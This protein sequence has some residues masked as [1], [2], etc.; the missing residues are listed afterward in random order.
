MTIMV[1]EAGF[2]PATSRFGPRELPLLHS[3]VCPFR[4]MILAALEL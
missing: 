1:A 2:E 4:G 3:A